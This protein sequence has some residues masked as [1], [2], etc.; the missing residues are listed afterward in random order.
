MAQLPQSKDNITASSIG[1]ALLRY[2]KVLNVFACHGKSQID[3]KLFRGGSHTV[4]QV[5]SWNQA[6]LEGLKLISL[7]SQ[8]RSQEFESPQRIADYLQSS[9]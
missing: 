8:K 7:G 5:L 1:Q 4:W 3:E 9:E 6:I 2:Q